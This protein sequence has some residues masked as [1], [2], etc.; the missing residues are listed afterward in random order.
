[1]QTSLQ[2]NLSKQ[3]WA[4][5]IDVPTPEKLPKVPGWAILAR[6]YAVPEKVGS[7]ILPDSFKDDASFLLTVGQVLVVGDCAYKEEKFVKPWCKPGDWI[8]WSKH[9]G[10]KLDYKGVKMILLNDD[11]VQMVIDDPNDFMLDIVPH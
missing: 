5:P 7:I 10:S 6:P 1:M 2:Q 4:T 11:Q 9:A 3:R 8:V